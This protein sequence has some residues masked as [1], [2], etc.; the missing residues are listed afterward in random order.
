MKKLMITVVAVIAAFSMCAC[1][2]KEIP[3]ANAGNYS[4]GNAE[5]T[6]KVE[7][8]DIEWA[9]GEVTVA[10]GKGNSVILEETYSGDLPEEHQM[11]WCLD[12]TTLRVRFD[13]AL[14]LFNIGSLG[15]KKLT[16]TLPESLILKDMDIDVASAEINGENLR[17]ENVDIDTASGDVKLSFREP[18]TNAEF[19]AASG[20]I[21]ADFAGAIENLDMDAAS[22]DIQVNATDQISEMKISTASGDVNVTFD[23][24]TKSMDIDTAS[25][26]VNL[27]LSEDSDLTLDV[28]TASGKFNSEIPFTMDGDKYI[29]GTGAA[30]GTIDTA[31]GDITISRK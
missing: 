18:L 13:Q 7:N 28:D 17:T 15:T 29:S 24:L 19:D 10:L 1:S 6:G 26:D 16:V 9:S 14:S 23:K 27:R 25:G 20:K 8:L 31:S 12:G 4:V 3:A 2:A 22:G 30:K 5:I 11:H 21:S